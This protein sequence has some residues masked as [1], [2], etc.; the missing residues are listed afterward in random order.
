MGSTFHSTEQFH[1]NKKVC[2]HTFMVA[3]KA[4]SLLRVAAFVVGTIN[5][6]R[7]CSC[8]IIIIVFAWIFMLIAHSRTLLQRHALG[9][10]LFIYLFHLN[11][12]QSREFYCASFGSIKGDVIHPRIFLHTHTRRPSN[13]VHPLNTF[14]YHV[15]THKPP[16]FHTRTT[17]PIANLF[18]VS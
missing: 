18:P 6:C 7:V 9:P 14:I 13:R 17:Q 15:T 3:P 11:E 1:N 2:F 8:R 16:S 5:C 10:G 4:R 12:K